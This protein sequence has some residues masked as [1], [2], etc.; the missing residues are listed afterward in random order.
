MRFDRGS[1]F[2]SRAMLQWS[3]E[4]K[5]SC[6][7]ATREGRTQNAQVESL[8][9][10]IRDELLNR[11]GLA[12][13]FDAQQQNDGELSTR[14]SGRIQPSVIHRRRGTAVIY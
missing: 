12:N 13:L 5:F 3:A 14:R 7:L 4:L 8:I 11:H 1:E 2:T 9:G 10:R 6:R